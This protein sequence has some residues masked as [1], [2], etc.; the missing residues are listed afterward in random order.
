[1]LTNFYLLARNFAL[2]ILLLPLMLTEAI[3]AAGGVPGAPGGG[4]GGTPSINQCKTKWVMTTNALP[5]AFGAFA[6]DSLSGTG[7]L[8]MNDVNQVSAPANISLSTTTPVSNFTVTLDNTKSPLCGAYGFT[9]NAIAA[10]ADLTGPGGAVMPLTL[11]V[12]ESTIPLA[13]TA[14]PVT[15][16]PASLPI[17]LIF[18]GSIIVT[19]PQPSGLYTSAISVDF[20]QA[21]TILSTVSTSTATSLKPISLTETV[22]MN[23]GTVAGGSLAGTVI[24]DTLGGRSVTGDAQ[25]LA[26]GP[27]AAGEFQISGEPSLSYLLTITGPAVLESALGDQINAS[28]FTNN[29]TGILPAGTGV[30]LFQIGATL[31]LAPLQ[32]AGTYSTTIGGGTPYTVTVNYN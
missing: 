15:L 6:I 25:I 4:G 28:A 7:T 26:V 31:N 22:P 19:D 2:A 8:T 23:F 16:S 20:D 10:P 29:S 27:G 21:G 12:S 3:A 30:E 18:Q 5:L 11:K 14:L 9:I 24:M 17:T 13:A 1:M 32:P